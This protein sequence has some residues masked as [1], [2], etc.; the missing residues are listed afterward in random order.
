MSMLTIGDMLKSAR[1]NKS[2][3]VEQVQ[4]QTRI[5]SS[6]LRALE[7]GRCDEILTPAYVKSFL[8]KY[9]NY[10]N[11]DT[12]AILKEYSVLHQEPSGRYEETSRQA[13]YAK[14]MTYAYYLIVGLVILGA[15][16][17]SIF[18]GKKVIGA[19]FKKKDGA[20][21]V[22]MSQR[23]KADT[24]EAKSAAPSPRTQ[25]VSR[26]S[27]AVTK[28]KA[29]SMV[30]K[31]KRNVYVKLWKD[32]KLLFGRVLTK[33]LAETFEANEKIDLYVAKSESI[34]VLIDG[35]SFGSPG[36]GIIRNLEVTK[37]GFRIK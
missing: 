6:V 35:K 36:K 37:S 20:R 10:L 19:V 16:F 14:Y 2:L 23:R 11:L 26:Q 4:K 5:H 32:G 9:S 31:V 22:S 3:S 21:R 17:M 33:G 29:F 12:A 28:S 34:D 24:H 25:A 30:L 7:E 27:A 8:K 1:E 18:I 15:I 13:D